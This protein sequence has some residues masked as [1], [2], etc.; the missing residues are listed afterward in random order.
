MDVK[1]KKKNLSKAVCVWFIVW[2][3]EC[4]INIPVYINYIGWCVHQEE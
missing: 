4:D 2:I 3:D 1:K